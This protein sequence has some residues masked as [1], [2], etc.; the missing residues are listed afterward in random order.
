MN[1]II[2]LAYLFFI[3]S[4]IGWIL[5]LFFR[6]FF[7]S[8]NPDHKWINPGFCT[9][10]YLPIYGCGLCICYI[11]S[12]F[13]EVYGLNESSEGMALLIL[14]IGLCMTVIE[15][16]AGIMLLK[17]ANLRLWDYRKLWGNV[18]GLICPLFS[19]FW[20]LL[21][22]LYYLFLHQYALS[23]VLWLMDN[24]AFSFIVGIFFGVFIVDLINSAQLVSKIRKYAEERELVVRYENFKLLIRSN[25]DQASKTVQ[26]MFPFHSNRSI[27]ELLEEAHEALEKRRPHRGKAKDQQ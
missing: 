3:G 25:M 4:V 23:A 14:L 19:F 10:P 2:T 17:V 22:G 13:G 27:N 6:K 12:Y 18:D 7:S 15:F 11:L 20:T 5:E 1:S 21:G 9:G 26:F 8:A 16:I 24:L